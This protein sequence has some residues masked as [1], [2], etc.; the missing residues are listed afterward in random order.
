MQVKFI[1]VTERYM[2]SNFMDTED[3]WNTKSEK[4]SINVNHILE[5]GKSSNGS[6][7]RTTIIWSEQP[8][9]YQIVEDY[10]MLKEIIK[11]LNEK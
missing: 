3:V 2:T 9:V 7:I 1:E 4:I 6:Y 10:E 8:L 11:Q 5:F